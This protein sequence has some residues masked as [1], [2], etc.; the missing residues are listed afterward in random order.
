MARLRSLPLGAITLSAALL[1]PQVVLARAVQPAQAAAQSEP[2]LRVLLLQGGEARL[3][4]AAAAVGLRL[5]D[6]QGRVLQ[7]F[8]DQVVLQVEPDG[9]WLRLSRADDPEQWQ[10]REAW[11]EALAGPEEQDPGCGWAS[12]VIAADCSCGL[13][14]ASCRW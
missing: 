6:G 11:L 3:R 14:R 2:V 10:V 5:R 1:A 13:R 9:T 4:P 12:A 7:D 8:A